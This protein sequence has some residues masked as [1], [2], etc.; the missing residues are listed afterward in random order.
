[1]SKYIFV[2]IDNSVSKQ[3]PR[4][5]NNIRKTVMTINARHDQDIYCN[6]KALISWKSHWKTGIN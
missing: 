3:I 4:N 6:T 5:N 2:H 1:M